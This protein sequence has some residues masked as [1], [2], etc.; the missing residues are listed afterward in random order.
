MST[1]EIFE[2]IDQFALMGTR[3]LS[4]TGGEPLIKSNLK[5]VVFYARKRGLFVSV[6]TNGVLLEKRSDA[7]RGASSINMTLD[8]P[9][10]IH[11][12]QRGDGTFKQTVE[13]VRK[14]QRMNIPLYLNCV[15]TKHNC[16]LLDEIVDLAK[17]LKVKILLQPVF[18]SA[19]SHASTL[20]GFNKVKFEDQDLANA[21]RK[22]IALKEI[23]DGSIMLS[24]KYY[25]QTLDYLTTGN[26][27]K[28]SFARK[29]GALFATI[30]PEGYVTPCNLL[31]RD[32]N[33]LNGREVGYHRAFFDM[34]QL[35]C[36]GCI[37][38]L[39]DVDY[40]LTLDKE[41]ISNYAG[42]YIDLLLPSFIKTLWRSPSRIVDGLPFK[43][44]L[45]TL[46][47]RFG[48]TIN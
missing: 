31:V 12:L 4:I 39:I 18:Y 32:K 29:D 24:K 7:I 22:L 36:G 30:S 37:S 10:A 38:S 41:V 9:E 15:L 21:L 2:M 8:G 33:Y 13:G 23:R 5:E 45:N 47:R 20:E 27:M 35:H 14:I 42:A 44:P 28:C 19:P 34:P 16:N 25:Q 1:A 6:A 48:L 26:K 17:E 3:R 43:I 40:L 46:K 11:D